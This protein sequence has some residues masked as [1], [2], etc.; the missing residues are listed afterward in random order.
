M[1]RLKV[2]CSYD[3]DF[4]FCHDLFIIVIFRSHFHVK[5]II[6]SLKKYLRSMTRLK[7]SG[8]D[9]FVCFALKFKLFVIKR[10]GGGSRQTRQ[11]TLFL[12]WSMSG[13]K[14]LSRQIRD[15]LKSREIENFEFWSNMQIFLILPPC[16]SLSLAPKGLHTKPRWPTL[17]LMRTA[18]SEL[19]YSIKIIDNDNLH[20]IYQLSR[21][22][23]GY[24]ICILF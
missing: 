1:Y 12:I 19:Y 4:I 9:N 6:S 18:A 21:L 15:N 8:P 3:F 13:L 10:C 22:L 20:L 11:E 7:C 16:A 23:P 2:W 14:E 5:L 24:C 17:N